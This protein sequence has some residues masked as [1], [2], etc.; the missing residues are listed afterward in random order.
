MVIHPDV[1]VVPLRWAVEVDHVTWHG[2]RFEAQRDKI[3]DRQAR[4]L[5]WQVERV[6][7]QELRD[8]FRRAVDDLE[9][10]FRLRHDQLRAA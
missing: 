3:R 8:S 10:L 1:A 9:E 7:D 4:R 5:G 6:T 2:G